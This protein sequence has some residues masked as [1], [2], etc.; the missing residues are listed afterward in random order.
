MKM[1]GFGRVIWQRRVV[2]GGVLL[3]ALAC[4]PLFAKVARP[5][6]EATSELAYVGSG[7]ASNAISLNNA[8]LPASDLPELAMSSDVVDRA[9]QASNI[10]ESVDDLRLSI[11]VKE[12]PHSNVVPIVVRSKSSAEALALANALADSTVVQYKLLAGR[13]YDDLI[14][15]IRGQLQE[16]QA[17]IRQIDA[18][19]QH[20]V[21]ADSAV[22]A[23][24]AL[25]AIS[26][27]LNDLEVQRTAANATYVADSAAMS[28]QG[29]AND[30]SGLS[31]AIREQILAADPLY[32]SLAATQSKDAA[33]LATVKAGYTDAFPGLAGLEE[34]VRSETTAAQQAAQNA[35]TEH[36]GNSSTY[37]QL[38]MNQHTA[39]ALASGDKAR[40]DAIDQDI[41]TARAALTDLPRNGVA[42]D[43]LRAQRD[44]AT[45]AYQQLEIRYQQT[46]ADRAQ[47]AALGAAFVLD[48]AN[49]A[50]PRI[51]QIVLAALISLFVL[52]LAIGSAYVAEALDPRIRTALDVEDLY[53]APRI[54]K[55]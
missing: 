41:A 6:Y 53:G 43:M 44:S 22:G 16:V 12:S 48:H 49:A 21:Q 35:I 30:G 7:S 20:S 45:A 34:K 29:D 19:L 2:F 40:V 51:P 31:K 42:A 32:Q 33:A 50:Y 47:A 17:Q 25:D 9:R 1:L 38:V 8:I 11:S 13:Q 39:T 23:S 28:A 36:P 5:T 55:V 10:D 15:S 14:G 3:L 54:G 27:H 18:G 4:S 37:A 52:V 24:D 46:L 26:K